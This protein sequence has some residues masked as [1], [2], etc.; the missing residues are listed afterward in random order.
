MYSLVLQCTGTAVCT[1][2]VHITCYTM[3]DK[4]NH[5]ICVVHINEFPKSDDRM[6][7]EGITACTEYRFGKVGKKLHNV[8]NK[9]V[10]WHEHQTNVHLVLSVYTG[11]K[12]EVIQHSKLQITKIWSVSVSPIKIWPKTIM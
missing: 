5:N 1:V 12:A 4:S 7:D 8:W 10:T 6:M 11:H 2:H 3:T 9:N